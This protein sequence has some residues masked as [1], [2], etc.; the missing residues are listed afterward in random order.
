MP[1]RVADPA[2]QVR[3]SPA[4]SLC[5]PYRRR[6]GQRPGRHLHR[7]R[8]RRVIPPTGSRA[9]EVSRTPNPRL[10]RPMLYPVELRAQQNEQAGCCRRVRGPSRVRRG[11]RLLWAPGAP[12]DVRP[13]SHRVP[14]DS[15]WGRTSG[16][17]RGRSSPWPGTARSSCRRPRSTCSVVSSSEIRPRTA[18]SQGGTPGGCRVRSHS[19]SASSAASKAGAPRTGRRRRWRAGGAGGSRS[20]GSGAPSSPPPAP[21]RGDGRR[22]RCSPSSMLAAA[23]SGWPI[24]IDC[25]S[26]TRSRRSPSTLSAAFTVASG[27]GMRRIVASRMMTI[28]SRMRVTPMAR[29]SYVAWRRCEKRALPRQIAPP[30]TKTPTGEKSHGSDRRNVDETSVKPNGTTSATGGL[31]FLRAGAVCNGGLKQVFLFPRL[32]T[33]TPASDARRIRPNSTLSNPEVTE[34]G[35]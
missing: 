23:S 8:G 11:R 5:P 30:G 10:R 1:A 25:S 22:D 16:A 35:A 4:G 6:R 21:S 20:G 28:R 29:T 19:A 14:P 12:P 2:H 3:R 24:S 27:R 15:A 26:A 13:A 34:G 17:A 9:P 33:L 32:T 7:G 31:G 18:S